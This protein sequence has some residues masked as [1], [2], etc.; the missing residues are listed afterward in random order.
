MAPEFRLKGDEVSIPF[1]MVRE[2]PFVEAE[3]DG[4]KG[5]LML[6]T[7]ASEALSLNH[8]PLK[9]EEGRDMGQGQFGSGQRFALVLRPGVD[10]V[11]LA[12]GLSYAR[13]SHVKSQDAKQLEGITPDFLGWLGYWFWDGYAVKMDYVASRATF[14]R[15]GPDAFL[16]GETVV[17]ALPF[18]LP[19]LPNHPVMTSKVGDVAFLTLFDTGQYG[20]LYTDAVTMKRLVDAAAVKPVAGEEESAADVTMRFVDGPEV[21]LPKLWTYPIAQA[22]PFAKPIGV[23][24][25][26][27]ILSLGHA[28]LKQYKTVWD[29]PNRTFYLLKK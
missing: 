9:L 16:K 27:N 5:K 4:V 13:V 23:D 10:N 3:I 29:Y 12:G 8:N 26:P 20:G 6:D 24:A 18:Q 11:R 21:V 25:A 7:G 22:A 14:Y 15:G 19:K 2:F 17:A 28:L 1:V